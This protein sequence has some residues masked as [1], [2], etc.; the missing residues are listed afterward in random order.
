MTEP[1]PPASEDPPPKDEEPT[2]PP[3][4]E[5]PPA[6]STEASPT[7]VADA[8]AGPEEPEPELDPLSMEFFL[9]IIVSMAAVVLGVYLAA[10]AGFSEASRFALLEDYHAASSSLTMVRAEFES[11]MQR[12]RD[13]RQGL[14]DKRPFVPVEIETAYFD[15]ATSTSAMDLV[16]PLVL[17]EIER[18]YTRPL[19]KAISIA[20]TRGR[21]HVKVEQYAIEVFTRCLSRADTV[22]LPLLDS[23]QRGLTD[24]EA[25]LKAGP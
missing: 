19:P 1:P 24:A 18:V 5:E 13:A 10:A 16:D 11:N 9:G 21:N 15:A 8:P 17:Y 14:K 7:P 3:A 4:A 25:E 6:P 2:P 23:A 22:V 20:S 12:L